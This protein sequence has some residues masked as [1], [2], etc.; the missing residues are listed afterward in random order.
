MI[1]TSVKPSAGVTV[2]KGR[3]AKPQQL[4]GRCAG[5]GVGAEWEQPCRGSLQRGIGA[6][7]CP[8]EPPACSS[9]P[10]GGQA[11]MKQE[12]WEPW[13]GWD[14]TRHCG[15]ARDPRRAPGLR[16][17][18][19]RSRGSCAVLEGTS[20]LQSRSCRLTYPDRCA[21]D[22]QTEMLGFNLSCAIPGEMKSISLLG[23]LRNKSE[24]PT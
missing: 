4:P 16:G 22:S 2:I 17:Q 12:M 14:H 8:T 11:W 21:K 18:L 19:G 7:P 13:A 5:R 3:R 9:L 23:L 10:S 20:S 24:H 1:K 15:E 6:H